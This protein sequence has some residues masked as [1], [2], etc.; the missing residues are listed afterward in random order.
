MTTTPAQT[1][2]PFWHLLDD[3]ALAD[4]TRFGPAGERIVL[5]GRITDGDGLAVVDACVELWQ[6]S[7]A[8]ALPG[9]PVFAGWGRCATDGTGGF[10]F[11]TLR[12][13][14]V[15]GPGN[16]WQAPHL[17]LTI[18]ARGI[19]SRLTTRVYFAG[20]PRNASD[21]VL[22]LIDE[23]SRR[24]TLLA[25]AEAPGTWRLDIRLQ[26]PGETVFLEV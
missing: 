12:P 16:T 23:P 24:A 2:G 20:D 11:V 6:A 7:P 13:G 22:G 8:A 9:D 14:A 5:V 26:G 15:P 4:L 3:P 25:I 10:R 1:I 21:P 19:L 18:F 17:A